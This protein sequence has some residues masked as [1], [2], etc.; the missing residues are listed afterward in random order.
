M[1]EHAHNTD[2]EGVDGYAY[3][4]DG[5]EDGRLVTHMWSAHNVGRY[6]LTGTYEVVAEN[7]VGDVL[8]LMHVALHE[9][10]GDKR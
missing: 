7:E 1:Q 6:T 2:A 9:A 3:T 8:A 10:R 5:Y 4:P